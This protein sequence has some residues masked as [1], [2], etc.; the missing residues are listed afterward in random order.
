MRSRHL[1]PRRTVLRG[2]GISLSLPWL[3]QMAW[4]NE[5]SPRQGWVPNDPPS[6]DGRPPL[7]LGF[8]M[9]PNGV[10]MPAWRPK[11][12]ER[13]LPPTLQPLD[14]VKEHLIILSGL[15]HD[16]ANANGDGAGDHARATATFL[17]GAQARKTAGN[18]I[19]VGVSVDQL[20]AS[21]IGHETVLPS[22]ELG[23]DGGAQAGS[24][25]SGYSCAY[26]SNI[27]WRTPTSPMTQETRPDAS[28]KRLFIDPQQAA[29]SQRKGAELALRN[30]VLDLV[31]EDAQALTKTLGTNDQRKL[32]QYLDSVRELEKRIQAAAARGGSA[33]TATAGPQL[34]L[35]KGRPENYDEHVRA[36]L[37]ILALAY[38][39]DAT[40]IGTFMF[41]NE[42]SNRAYRTLGVTE[43]HHTLSHHGG[44]AAK[45][46]AIQKIN[47]HHITLFAAFLAKLK[48]MPEGKGSVLDNCLI[49]YGSGTSDGDRHNHDDLPVLLA[50]RGG[51]TVVSGRHIPAAKGNMCDLYLALL[52]RVGVR[53]A[54]FGDGT[55]PLPDLS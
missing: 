32:D 44:D 6:A 28:F 12:G 8:L 33:S 7:R 13:A 50:G 14:A 43:G 34:A 36:M 3:E 51:G 21:R 37:D 35:P 5:P 45:T 15:R 39:T 30:S 2:L 31:G 54:T 9:V 27:S 26:S 46:A 23:I 49:M 47:H 24:C 22:I 55:K 19:Q 38:Q 29:G 41:A 52:H 11:A 18:D 1:L 25:D 10:H 4:G 17:T 48:A 53:V 40:R 42:G 20:A 16:K